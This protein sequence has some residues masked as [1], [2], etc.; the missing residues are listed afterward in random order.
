MMLVSAVL[1]ILYV[2]EPHRY[3]NQ[4]TTR[5]TIYSPNDDDKEIQHVP[6]VAQIGALVHHE[7]H[8]DDLH[9]ALGREDDEEHVLDVL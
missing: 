7:T 5:T 6:A 2:Y 9:E 3:N 4:R 1:T 8:R